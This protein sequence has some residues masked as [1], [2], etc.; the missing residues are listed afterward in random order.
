MTVGPHMSVTA[1]GGGA[2]R[3]L[4]KD[5]DEAGLRPTTA[6]T[7]AGAG[8]CGEAGWARSC[9]ARL[10]RPRSGP[11]RETREGERTSANKNRPELGRRER[12][13]G[14]RFF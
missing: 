13:K 5:A 9:A 4:H 3:G 2:L 6:H 10:R 1:G 12:E 14:K 8:L 11:G 7:R